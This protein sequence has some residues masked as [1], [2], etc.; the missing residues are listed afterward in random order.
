MK[1]LGVQLYSVRDQLA[2][3]RR[4]VLERIAEIGYTA[5]E[6][7]DPLDDPAGMRSILDNLGLSVWSTHAP[8]LGQPE[9]RN[10][11]AE[12]A[13]ILGAP[14]VVVASIPRAEYST[15]SAADQLNEAADWADSHGLRLG[16]HNHDWEALAALADELD[17]R[18]V[19]EVD[20]Y[21]AAVSGADV[22]A[23][24]AHLGGR[25]ALLHVKDG[26]A[27]RSEPMTAVGAG[28]LPIPA[29]LAAA[30][31]SAL[32]IVEIDRCATDMLDALA[33]SYRYLVSL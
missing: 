28:M 20:V 14:T 26:P 11:I 2:V 4:E 5:V 13:A 10:E 21:W 23:L 18:V 15:S 25:V 24:L 33:D 6:P 16:Y 31:A 12:A 29:I 3:D 9:R 30:P 32:R 8:V 19:L 17:P 7:A 27:V 22:P 1:S